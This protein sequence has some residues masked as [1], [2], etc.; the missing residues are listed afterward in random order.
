M[1]PHPK[2]QYPIQFRAV[3][4]KNRWRKARHESMSNALTGKRGATVL[5]GHRNT[6]IDYLVEGN[7]RFVIIW[8][9]DMNQGEIV[10]PDNTKAH[11]LRH[12]T[13]SIIDIN[14]FEREGPPSDEILLQYF[15]MRQSAAPRVPASKPAKNAYRQFIPLDLNQV[16]AQLERE[17][18]ASRELTGEARRARLAT[19][20]PIARCVEISTSAFIRNADVI[21]ETLIRAAGS[22]EDCELPAPFSR[23]SDGTPYL[24]VHHRT[25]LSKGGEDTVENAVALCPNCHRRRHYGSAD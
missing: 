20:D 7:P 5:F 19:A 2:R 10:M 21:I 22:C 13:I 15:E 3:H 12:A 14:R 11:Y 23:K 6:A 4:T 24:E 1:A 17:L 9:K 18:S 8:H 16:E 25:P